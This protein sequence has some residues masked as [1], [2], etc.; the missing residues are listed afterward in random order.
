M[1]NKKIKNHILGQYKITYNERITQTKNLISHSDF[2]NIIKP[3]QKEIYEL[4]IRGSK[5]AK[6]KAK[7]LKVELNEMFSDNYFTDK[8]PLYDAYSSGYLI[9]PKIQGG[10]KTCLVEKI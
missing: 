7:E 4:E 5:T 3:K 2:E 9:L 10:T 8:S 6:K 1:E